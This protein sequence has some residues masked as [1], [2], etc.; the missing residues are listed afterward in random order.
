MRPDVQAE[1]PLASMLPLHL[2]LQARQ[3]AQY[4][5]L[6]PRVMT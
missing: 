4:Y 1:P 5:L 2:V 3:A 6:Q